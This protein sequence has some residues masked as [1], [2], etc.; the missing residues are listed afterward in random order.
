MSSYVCVTSIIF[1]I[2]LENKKMT[3]LEKCKSSTTATKHIISGGRYNY[4]TVLRYFKV[5]LKQIWGI[6]IVSNTQ[7]DITE[8]TC[9]RKPYSAS[10]GQRWTETKSS[11]LVTVSLLIKGSIISSPTLVCA[12]GLAV[13]RWC[14]WSW[15]LFLPCLRPSQAVRLLS[16]ISVA[17]LW[18]L[19]W[20]GPARNCHLIEN[21]GEWREGE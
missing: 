18:Q 6:Y 16:S 10:N 9:A 7:Q 4:R 11:N 12:G 3:S 17:S 15:S 13:T 8:Y 19:V 1:S 2:T 21:D 20:N 5:F 14:C